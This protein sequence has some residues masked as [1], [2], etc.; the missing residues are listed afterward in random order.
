[1]GHTICCGW[2]LRS[3]S[4]RLVGYPAEKG[5]YPTNEFIAQEGFGMLK[6]S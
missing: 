1:M 2:F 3:A 5:L 6:G 4:R